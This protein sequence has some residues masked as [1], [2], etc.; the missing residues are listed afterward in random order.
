MNE[1]INIKKIDTEPLVGDLRFQFPE[2]IPEDKKQ[3]YVES[4]INELKFVMNK[5]QIDKMDICWSK[6]GR[7]T[8]VSTTN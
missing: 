8:L 4:L 6:F 5:Y 1:P 2:G 3:L 7:L